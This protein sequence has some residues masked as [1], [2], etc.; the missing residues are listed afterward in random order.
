MNIGSLATTQVLIV[1]PRHTLAQAARM[2]FERRS[3]SALV[4]D[5]MEGPGIITERDLL[6][7]V[8]EG[9]DL[10]STPVENYMTA[11]AITA[12]ASWDAEKAARLML[13]RGF[14]HLV[15]IDDRGRIEGILSIRDL[16]KALLD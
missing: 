12:S 9:V 11:N 14:R 6:R 7:A 15:V 8:A 10:A 5:D 16:I 2:M 1:G 3:G 13:E 4:T